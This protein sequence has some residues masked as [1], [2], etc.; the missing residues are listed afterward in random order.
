MKRYLFFLALIISVVYQGF[1]QPN[2]GNNPYDLTKKPDLIYDDFRYNQYIDSLKIGDKISTNPD[3]LRQLGV[4]EATIAELMQV[5]VLQDSLTQLQE[6]ARKR[7]AERL[8][9]E[10]KK[11]GINY[12]NPYDTTVTQY[13]DILEQEKRRM[14]WKALTAPK[15]KVYGQEFFRRNTVKLF[16][17]ETKFKAPDSYIIGEGDEL[18]INAWGNNE[19]SQKVTV[20]NTGSI[21][22][23]YVGWV[24][25]KGMSFGEAK[26]LLE[27]KYSNV[28]DMKRTT[29]NVDINH[30][31]VITVNVTGDAISPGSYTLPAMNTAFNV[32]VATNGPS[33]LGSVR[34]IRIKR[35]GRVVNTL[36]VYKYLHD[37]GRNQDFFV[38]NNDY[39]QI[40]PVQNIV[41]LSGAVKRPFKYEM[42]RDEG[43]VEL[44]KYSGGFAAN[45]FRQNV[46]IKRNNGI[47]ISYITIDMDSITKRGVNY[48]LL[49]GD[50]IFVNTLKAKPQN[51]VAIK[52]AVMAPGHYQLRKGEKVS[53]L[54]AKAGG[55]DESSVLGQAYIIRLDEDYN[56]QLIPINLK[57][58]LAN[59]FS[60]NLP[61][62]TNDTVMVLS[63]NRLR[64]SLKIGIY[65]SVKL[66]GEY[67]F[68]KNMTLRD[69][70][71]TAGGFTNEAAN[72]KIEVSR[73]RKYESDEVNKSLSSRSLVTTFRV[74]TDLNI[75]DNAKAFILE[76]YDKIYVRGSSNFSLE[77]NVKIG[78]EVVYPG[79]YPLETKRDRLSEIIERAGGLNDWAH[80]DAA[81][82]YRKIDSTTYKPIVL[83]LEKA[84]NMPNSKYDYV[85]N[86]GDS[87]YIPKF[88]NVVKI[89]GKVN[90][91]H[92]DSLEFISVP[93]EAGKSAR[94]YVKNYAGG[95]SR[96][97][98]RS[99]TL[100]TEEG[101][102][103]DYPNRFGLF[104]AF[105]VVENGATITVRKKYKLEDEVLARKAERDR[106]RAGNDPSTWVP[107]VT[108]VVG[109]V[110][111]LGT[112]LLVQK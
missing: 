9:T 49:D 112:I 80:S 110:V 82:L 7:E 90:H 35:Q 22:A 44:I 5:S 109:A 71:L 23:N 16:D 73:M 104:N 1:S 65:G 47:S 86:N 75:D 60:D 36:D 61:L 69:L 103:V 41:T 37:E 78:G 91:L 105:P 64:K 32:L 92:I 15:I 72:N 21:K 74:Y 43:I 6:L 77:D 57:S 93:Y 39:V 10:L 38:Q 59:G 45:A 29:L 58:A 68:A 99:R 95:F 8:Q 96:D 17:D 98:N 46:L 34:M 27:S 106:N 108:A 51:V 101:G 84:L 54:V 13:L 62:Q 48:K 100:I 55:I 20:D 30:S 67:E 79:E 12:K 63:K 50:S 24:F 89:E 26:K 111:S 94:Y 88:S 87:L 19:M 11:K 97:A 40:Q 52:G 33:D 107:V 66:P 56:K 76:G 14:I 102:K 4:S 25:V 83:K 31:R 85:V 70:I 81:K 42:L 18:V 3:E 2:Y 53:N 28:F